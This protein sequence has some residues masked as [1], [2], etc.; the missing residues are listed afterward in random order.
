MRAL[1]VAGCVLAGM[2]GVG[3]TVWVVNH[4]TG[5]I[6]AEEAAITEFLET[7]QF[8]AKGETV[9]FTGRGPDYRKNGH[10]ILRRRLRYTMMGGQ[11]I[12]GDFLFTMKDGKVSAC[13]PNMFGD[14]VGRMLE[15]SFKP[16]TGIGSMKSK[17]G[18][19][20]DD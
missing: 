18:W 19:T 13:A 9:V 11:V 3:G 2:A 8:L 15:Q 7:P 16:E 6:D 1:L 20:D 10:T 4:R 17:A 12:D 5:P 14:D